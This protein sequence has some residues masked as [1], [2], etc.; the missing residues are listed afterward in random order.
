MPNQRKSEAETTAEALDRLLALSEALR[1]RSDELAEEVAKLR[2][3]V[4]GGAPNERR[5]RPR[6]KGK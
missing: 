2:E 1:Q 3:A 4:N 5:K 6:A